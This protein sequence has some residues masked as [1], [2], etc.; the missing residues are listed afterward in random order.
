M[1]SSPP[2]ELERARAWLRVKVSPGRMLHS[3]GVLV[4][5]ADLAAANGVD[6]A[7]L[8]L[9]A[10]I[11]DAAREL[12]G[13]QMLEHARKWGLAIRPVDRQ[14][15]VLLH[16]RVGLQMARNELGAVEPHT[17]SAVSYHT[18]GHPDMSLSDKLFFL[19]DHVEPGR[20]FERLADLRRAAGT[21]I[22]AAVMLA[23]EI[24]LDYLRSSGKTVDPDTPL[25]K[26]SLSGLS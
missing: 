8:M 5:V 13:V 12:S 17:A 7:P 9:A 11:H 1:D 6:P 20:G 26:E 23:I 21:D 22:D 15:P 10:L 24:N 25:L 18:A 19:A 3:E 16:G 14:S 2:I 4:T